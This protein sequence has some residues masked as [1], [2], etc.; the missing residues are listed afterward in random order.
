ME[1]KSVIEAIRAMNP[2]SYI[3]TGKELA[4][5]LSQKEDKNIPPV[6]DPSQR[7]DYSQNKTPS[8]YVCH[9]CGATGVRLWREN[10][11]IS[12]ISLLCFGCCSKCNE[13]QDANDKKNRL[14][15]RAIPT[16]ENDTF[17]GKKSAPKEG[18]SWWESLPV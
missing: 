5:S 8:N 4:D 2:D 15:I 7:I 3:P 13:N 16:E 11:D 17:W 12:K 9:N 1:E 18:I 6:V 14:R 10:I